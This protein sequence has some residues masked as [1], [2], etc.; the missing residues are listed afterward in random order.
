M[1]L[2][3]LLFLMMGEVHANARLP[4][5]TVIDGS[6]LAGNENDVDRLVGRQLTRTIFP[7]RTISFSDT[8]EADLV[9]RNSTV[10]IVAVKGPMRIETKGRALGAGAEGEEILVMNLESRRTI[11]AVISGPGE[12]RV[13]L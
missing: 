12:V 10:R 1:I 6:G 2:T 4:A 11:T 5:G 7:G 13:E 9:D 3:A 8:K